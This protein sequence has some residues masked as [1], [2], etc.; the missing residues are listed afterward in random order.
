MGVEA[1]QIVFL[2]NPKTSAIE[3]S[4]IS[5]RVNLSRGSYPQ[6]A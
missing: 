5:P 4:E 1:N 3:L 6:E 2:N